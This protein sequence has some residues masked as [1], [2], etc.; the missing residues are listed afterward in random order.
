VSIADPKHSSG[1][2]PVNSHCLTPDYRSR[3]FSAPHPKHCRPST[4]S[5]ASA[6][7]RVRHGPVQ[8]LLP[9]IS[10][11]SLEHSNPLLDPCFR[12]IPWQLIVFEVVT[13]ILAH[14]AEKPWEASGCSCMKRKGRFPP[15]PRTEKGFFLG[16]RI[17]PFQDPPYRPLGRG[18][19][20][21]Q[22]SH[23]GAFFAPRREDRLNLFATEFP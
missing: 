14:C 12:W 9:L 20:A 21:R 7:A 8:P 2:A 10:P 16:A 11:V 15:V 18:K 6:P 1:V 19:F 23:A 17:L 5:T 22:F 4:E 13:L 3:N